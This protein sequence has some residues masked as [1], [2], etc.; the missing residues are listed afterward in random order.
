M[1]LSIM[2]APLVSVALILGM[3]FMLVTRGVATGIPVE[4][5][6]TSGHS[7]DQARSRVV[8]IDAGGKIYVNDT[9]MSLVDVE[10]ALAKE[11]STGG[12]DSVLLRAD[13]RVP[14][15]IVAA[16]ISAIRNAGIID[17]A[18][19]TGGGSENG[20]EL[21]GGQGSVMVVP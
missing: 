19:E 21:P 20:P 18:I 17:I 4:L 15:D 12:I 16:T 3:F 6:G 11:R 2:I 5:P 10:T 1:G 13:R 14:F 7:I 8:M 9:E